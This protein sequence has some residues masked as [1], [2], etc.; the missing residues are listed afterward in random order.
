[1]NASLVGFAP[2]PG[3]ARFATTPSSKIEYKP[4]PE[5][6]V[7]FAFS[8]DFS[9]VALIRKAKPAWQAGLLNGIGGKIEPGETPDD[10]MVR[11]FFEETGVATVPWDWKQV[12]VIRGDNSVVHFF[13]SIQDI[14]KCKTMEKEPVEIHPTYP[15]PVDT[16]PNVQW[17]LPL[18]LDN[19][20]PFTVFD[21]GG[22]ENDKPSAL[23][24]NLQINR[25]K[26]LN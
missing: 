3:Y 4:I 7:G 2:S 22:L 11:E 15:L 14:T 12:V 23:S 17:T 25:N 13:T 21:T 9:Q 8:S 5:Y 26:S 6:V 20:E 1:M 16:V 24:A 18:A 19:I 10:A